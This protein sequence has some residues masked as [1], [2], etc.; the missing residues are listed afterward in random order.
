MPIQSINQSPSQSLQLI[1][2]EWESNPDQA[3]S[4]SLFSSPE[5]LFR[6]SYEHVISL[7]LDNTVLRKHSLFHFLLGFVWLTTS[8]RRLFW[9]AV[10]EPIIIP[11]DQPRKEAE[12]ANE[13][14]KGTIGRWNHR[15][16]SHGQGPRG[17]KQRKEA[18]GKVL[19][20]C[21]ARRNYTQRPH[22]RTP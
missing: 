3:A 7:P 18:Q 11:P 9:V 10:T 14:E 1:S 19:P 2:T 21:L 13:E 15:I 4:T 17:A 6:L 12:E 5:L 20:G 8:L 16:P 22:I